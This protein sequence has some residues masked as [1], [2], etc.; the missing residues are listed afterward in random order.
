[1]PDRLPPSSADAAAP[2]HRSLARH[3]LAERNGEGVWEGWL[4]SSALATAVAAFALHLAAPRTAAATVARALRWLTTHANADGGWGDTPQSLSNPSTTLLCLA[5]LG[6]AHPE[7]MACRAARAAA[8]AWIARHAGSIAP[9]DLAT[10]VLRRYGSDRTFSVPILTLCALAGL[11]GPDPEAWR[12]VPGLPFELAVLPARWLRFAGLPTVSYALPALIAMGLAGHRRRPGRIPGLARLRETLAPAAL[13][14][15]DR[16][17]PSSGGFLEAA[18]LTAFVAASLCG[19]GEPQHPVV[20]RAVS[21]LE[22]TVR[23]DG[24]WPIDVHLK[25]WVTTQA[26]AALA[27]LPPDEAQRLWNPAARAAVRDWLLRTQHRVPHPYTGAAPGGWSWTD[28]PG[29]VPD[30]DDT[31]GALLALR[32]LADASVPPA[33]AA[34][35]AAETGL[36]WLL[37]LQNRDGGLPTFCR[38]WGRLPFDR[39]CPD[40]TAHALSAWLAWRDDSPPSLRAQIRPGI[41]RAVRYLLRTQQADG[42]WSPLWFGNERAPAG[43]NRTYG[44]ARVALALS[45]LPPTEQTPAVRARLDAARSWLRTHQN[46]DGGWGGGP[47][48]PSSPEETGLALQALA[49][50]A[51]PSDTAAQR[52]LAW[53]QQTLPADG[54]FHPT[55]IGLYFACLWYWERLYPAIFACAAASA[56]APDPPPSQPRT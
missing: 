20:A 49:R 32:A 51:A 34:R 7:D 35:E 55:P 45:R 37:G 6:I 23:E 19:A 1:M 33:P 38:G 31:A 15:L 22:T 11:L 9:Q 40:L 24:S 29:G 46:T 18:P 21:F 47:G 52:G 50:L 44:T 10:L 17:Q 36:R 54:S 41:V 16:L 27:E 28:R 26:V 2:F 53:L 42:S 3:L 25:T 12:H 13:R 39:S 30:A 48:T 14:R 5:A 4:A 8:E 43:E 56:C